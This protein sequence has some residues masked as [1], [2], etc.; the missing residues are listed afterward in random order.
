MEHTAPAW[1]AAIEASAFAA[2]MRES[3]WLYPL[4]GVLHVVAIGLLLGTIVAFDLRVLGV[5]ATVPLRDAARWLL[6]VARVGFALAVLTGL[7]MFSADA[8]HLADNPAF[9]A[10]LGL[11]LLAGLNV[12][13]FHLLFWR[14]RPVPGAPARGSAA[15]SMLGWISVASAGR[16]IAYF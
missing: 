3:L 6:P 14:G 12:L 9:L 2:L 11:V 5:A 1:I 7:A 10:K 15:A 13:L 8:S 4:A 16:L